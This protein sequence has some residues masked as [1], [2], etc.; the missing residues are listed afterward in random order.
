MRL[1][2][3]SG[4]FGKLTAMIGLAL[5]AAGTHVLAASSNPAAASTA[6]S[7]YVPDKNKVLRYAFEV[8]ES[9]MDPQKVSDV[10][11]TIVH[12]AIFDT[13]LRYDY[14]ARPLKAVPNTLVSMP[15]VTDNH[16]TFTMRVKPGI[17]FAD[18]PVF[19]GKK[20]ELT[21]E[22]YVFS[23]K[24]LFDPKL[25]APLLAEVEGYVVGSD[26]LLKRVR[27]ANKMDYDT[28][29][30]GLRAL[31]RYTFQI[32]LTE[33]K[34]DFFYVLTDCR[35]S[36]AVARE[37][38]EHYGTDI[39]SNPVGT[40]AYTLTS[41]KRSS[42]MVFEYNPNFREAYFEGEPGADDKAGQEILAKMKGK[43]IPQV[44]RVEVAIIEERQP[45]YL[46]FINNEFDLIWLFPEDFANM[47]FPNRTLAPNLKKLGI[48]MQQVAALD[49]TYI[50]FNME[51]KTVGGYKPENVALRRAI[52]LGYKTE[53]EINIIRKGQAIPAH[54]PYA[55]GVQGWTPD[56]RTSANE[57]DPAKARALLDAFGY[58]V[59]PNDCD[60]RRGVCYRTMPDGSP[61]VLK[62]NSTPTD[63]DK[64][65]DEL[66]KRSMD[67]IGIRI[68]VTKGKW[69][70]FLK[71]SDAGKLMMW[72]LGGSATSPTAE[73]WLQS[74]Y[75]PNSGFKGNRARFQLKEYD[76]LFAKSELLPD[77]P[78]RTKLYQEMA[79][80]VVA[81]APWKI[82]THRILTDLYYPYLVGFRRP[83]VQSQSWWRFVD[84]DVPLMKQYEAK[85]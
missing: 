62:S 1:Q 81:Y 10:Y 52:S 72:Q 76:E 42:R 49:L 64:Q 80:L 83:A 5:M 70:D 41:W 29:L 74:L 71:A 17:Y 58:K 59:N 82:N 45:R 25:T 65:F 46:S 47:S 73:T 60:V 78:E 85:R 9:S 16:K 12:N 38:V 39:G 50:Y 40:G 35:V 79:R 68:E 7:T 43:R 48:Q 21:A 31:D 33:T 34:P 14:L 66:W 56:F 44:Y 69:P 36:C 84:I 13:P 8:A 54:T 51:D 2:S 11:S 24:R 4:V 57:Y 53:D 23:I 67:A 6:A 18:H 20:R 26:E 22:D 19:G 77:S 75:G 55:P 28:P 63:R 37:I 61:L 30:E 3:Q 27:K 15:E 32:K